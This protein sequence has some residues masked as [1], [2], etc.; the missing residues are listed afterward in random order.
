LVETSAASSKIMT[1]NLLP[2]TEDYWN[3]LCQVL[4]SSTPWI[5]EKAWATICM[6][7]DDQEVSDIL[8]EIATAVQ[9]SSIANNIIYQLLYQYALHCHKFNSQAVD[10]ELNEIDKCVTTCTT[11]IPTVANT[12][13]EVRLKNLATLFLILRGVINESNEQFQQAYDDF[14]KALMIS[15]N[16]ANALHGRGNSLIQMNRAAEALDDLNRAISLDTNDEESYTARGNA[17]IQMKKY[18]EA[19]QDFTTAIQLNSDDPEP[20]YGRAQCYRAL[21][22]KQEA[23]QDERQARLL[24]DS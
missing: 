22:R 23:A 13:D 2:D 17:L 18:N 12:I 1:L 3:S 9:Q 15:P 16:D 4:D 8:R 5:Q 20:F 7:L 11:M 21:N 6:Q 14:T 24:E 19:I 10:I